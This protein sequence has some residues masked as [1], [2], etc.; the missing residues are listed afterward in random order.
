MYSVYIY[1][2]RPDEHHRDLA[3]LDIPKLQR[4]P[5]RSTSKPVAPKVF[6]EGEHKGEKDQK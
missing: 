1:I 2:Y 5:W 6:C 3:W 4:Q